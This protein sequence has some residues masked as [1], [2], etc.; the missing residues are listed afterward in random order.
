MDT[1]ILTLGALAILIAG[2][3]LLDL[4]GQGASADL[5]REMELRIKKSAETIRGAPL[6]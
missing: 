2:G 6:P 4:F 5:E 1:E 3:W